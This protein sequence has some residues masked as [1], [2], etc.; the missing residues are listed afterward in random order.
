M[1]SSLLSR[2]LAAAL[3]TSLFAAPV[4]LL[5]ISA[6]AQTAQPSAQKPTD[7][8]IDAFAVAMLDVQSIA[9]AYE[10]HLQKAESDQETAQIHQKA[11]AEMTAAVEA[12]GLEVDRYNAIAQAAQAD[13]DLAAT[14]RE[15]IS[16]A[17][18]R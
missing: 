18:E 17:A 7:K 2:A 10:P 13:E 3:A 15:K 16:E 8:E 5:P 9:N 14:I 11:T 12:Q 6:A 1:P 4:A